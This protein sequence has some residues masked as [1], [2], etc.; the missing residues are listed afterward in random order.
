VA[1][2]AIVEAPQRLPARYAKDR[3]RGPFILDHLDLDYPSPNPL[4]SCNVK[5]AVMSF[6]EAH[7]AVRPLV[8]DALKV[9]ELVP[10]DGFPAA[11]VL[12][13]AHLYDDVYHINLCPAAACP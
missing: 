12:P 11:L 3:L 13:V 2:V 10:L 6:G 1:I 7:V 8:A 5:A 4:I 9:D